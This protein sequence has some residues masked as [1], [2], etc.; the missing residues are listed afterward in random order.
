MMIF[1]V[2][3]RC[4]SSISIMVFAVHE[5]KIVMVFSQAMLL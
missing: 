4:A 1:F 2:M 5:V 3:V